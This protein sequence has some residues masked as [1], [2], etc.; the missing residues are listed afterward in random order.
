MEKKVVIFF[1][2]IG[3]FATILG[4]VIV[5]LKEMNFFT[6]NTFSNIA[7]YILIATSLLLTLVLTIAESRI[8]EDSNSKE[9]IHIV[10]KKNGKQRIVSIKN[11]PNAN[12]E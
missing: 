3:V 9:N 5:L 2:W 4:T 11:S 6:E 10:N 7:L 12:V 1:K 8:K